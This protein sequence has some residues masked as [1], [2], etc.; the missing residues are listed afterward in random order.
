MEKADVL[1]MTVQYLRE[2]KRREQI[3]LQGMYK[4]IKGIECNI[5]I[6]HHETLSL[7]KNP[8]ERI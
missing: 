3:T 2:L 1:E 8:E 6:L 4:Y 7:S 5:Y